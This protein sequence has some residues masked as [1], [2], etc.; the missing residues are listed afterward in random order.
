M[1]VISTVSV[2]GSPENWAEEG[3]GQRRH[4]EEHWLAGPRPKYSIQKET[5]DKAGMML[6]NAEGLAA[7]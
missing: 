5:Q 1:G 4:G 2:E 6:L 3:G 7:P